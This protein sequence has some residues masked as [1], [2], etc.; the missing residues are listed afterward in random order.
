MGGAAEGTW[1]IGGDAGCADD[2]T[3]ATAAAEVAALGCGDAG[4]D[5]GPG[6]TSAGAL[7]AGLD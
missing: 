7:G 1:R 5:V 4:G 3:A 6:E 2:A